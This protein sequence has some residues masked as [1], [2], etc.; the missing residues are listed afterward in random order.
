[1]N[2]HNFPNIRE[3]IKRNIAE[4]KSIASDPSVLEP[5]HRKS[6]DRGVYLFQSITKSMIDIGNNI[7]IAHGYRTPLNTADVFISLAEHNVISPGVVPGMKKAAITLPKIKNQ[8]EAEL[9]TVMTT[10]VDY[11]SRCLGAYDMYFKKRVTG[12]SGGT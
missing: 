2:V 10:C 7:I 4:I 8:P 12:D 3:N 6:F 1:M 9:I 5:P 11:F